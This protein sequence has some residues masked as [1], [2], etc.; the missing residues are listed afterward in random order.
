MISTLLKQ[1]SLGLLC[2]FVTI[3]AW[4]Q[5]A[6]RIRLTPE[7]V[8]NETGPGDAAKLVDEQEAAGDP[9]GGNGGKPESRWKPS[10]MQG[11]V[12][13][14][15]MIDLGVEHEVDSL[16]CYTG[17]ARG[18]MEIFWGEPFAWK[19]VGEVRTD[20]SPQW[21]T[22]K[23]GQKTRFL[24]LAFSSPFATPFE[25]V[26]YGKALGVA[27][28]PPEPKVHLRTTVDQMIGTNAFIDDPIDKI[29]AVGYVREYHVWPW[30]EQKDGERAW[31][32]SR[33]G[34][35][36]D[37]DEFYTKLKEKGIF[38]TP[39][40]Q[41]TPAWVLGAKD[42]GFMYDTKPVPKG[43]DPEDPL[44]YAAHAAHLYQFMARYGS[45]V[46]PDEMLKLA[47]DQKRVSGLNLISYLENWNEQDKFWMPRPAYFTA[48]EYAAMSSAD[49][50]GHEGKL[51]AG[52]GIKA[53]DPKA[54]LVMGGAAATALDFI[55]AMKL[56]CDY[57]RGGKFIWDAINV[58]HYSSNGS[59]QTMGDVGMSPEENGLKGK[60]ERI[61]DYR[62]RYLPGVE[63]WVT[64]FGYDTY[65]KSPQRA[66]KIG[67]TSAEEIQAQWLIR[68]F[69]E[70]AAAGVDR[71]AMYM[72]RDVD[73]TNSTRFSSSGL[74]GPKGSWKPKPSWFY[75]NTMRV[76]LKGLRYAGQ[77][78]S[79]NPQVR[80]YKF[81]NDDG[82]RVGY[83]VWC[84]TAQ[85][86]VVPDFSFAVVPLQTEA[87]LTKLEPGQPEGVA[88]QLNVTNGTVT[89]EASERPVFV[90]LTKP[91][92]PIPAVQIK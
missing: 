36:W 31:S 59:D 30:D 73:P 70:L 79:G 81:A 76:T 52:Y 27:P 40:M 60:M 15:A 18:K 72:L 68:G 19:S 92:A 11:L 2:G 29:A 54:K 32:P 50:D 17:Q 64:E 12:P 90:V 69:L 1:L 63:F 34:G 53:A 35:G 74:V 7:M 28:A 80:V 75:T 47:S 83:A 65:E 4:G 57:K 42:A 61:R 85:E 46:V 43:Q 14:Y 33:A 23:I 37:F 20:R 49:Y 88:C 91:P 84:I 5:E 21:N 71:A 6:A 51:G 62:D 44:S 82:S 26:L 3:A 8:L 55:R 67:Q 25:V 24:R 38:V 45:T 39:V 41:Q 48:F 87:T 86:L 10:E 77:E 13:V 9:A 22:A 58:H 78:P 89:V 56:W 66:P 16:Y